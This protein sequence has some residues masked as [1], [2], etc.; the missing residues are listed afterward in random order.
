MRVSVLARVIRGYCVVAFA[1]R[2]P[3]IP[4]IHS[5]DLFHPHVDPDDHFDLATLFA[6]KEFDIKGIVL[7]NH[8]SDQMTGAAGR[9]S[10]R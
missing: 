5:T 1:A 7:D 10:S 2:K 8:G 9:P 3:K 4:I 6:V